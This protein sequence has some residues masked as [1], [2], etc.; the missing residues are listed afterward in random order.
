MDQA[1]ELKDTFIEELESARILEKS[2][3]MKSATILASKALFALCDYIIF[4]KYQKLPKNHAE[5]FRILE[6]KEPKI[7]SSV[8]KAWSKY[9]DTYSKPSEKESYNILIKSI[10]EIAENEGINIKTKAIPKK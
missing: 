1:K 6:L 3:R 9:T 4:I 7:Y 10:M 2:N 8:N 5:R